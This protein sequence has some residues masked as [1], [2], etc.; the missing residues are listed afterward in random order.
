MSIAVYANLFKY[1]KLRVSRAR[2]QEH[3]NNEG[4]RSSAFPWFRVF[5]RAGQEGLLLLLFPWVVL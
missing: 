3:G 4:I 1:S 5:R 2:L